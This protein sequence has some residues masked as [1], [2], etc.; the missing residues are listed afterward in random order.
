MH[1]IIVHLPANRDYAGWLEVRGP[2]GRRIAGPF[3]VCGRAD[4]RLAR[5]EGNPE[6]NPLLPGGDTPLGEFSATRI[7]PSGPG[8]PYD[9]EEFG[10]AGVVLLEPRRGDAALADATG[11]F[12]LMIHGGAPSRNGAL[13]PTDGSLRLANRD[14]RTL[15]GV[16]RQAGTVPCHCVPMGA[17]RPKSKVAV[18][19]AAAGS[20]DEESARGT[21]SEPRLPARH[22]AN[23]SRRLWLRNVM[24]A[25]GATVVIPSALIFSMQSAY[26]AAAEGDYSNPNPPPD[27]QPPKPPDPDNTNLI[28]A[29]VTHSGT[30]DVLKGTV[31]DDNNAVKATK[32]ETT[33][34]NGQSNFDKRGSTGVG[35]AETGDNTVT[36][37]TTTTT[38]NGNG[39]GGNGA[40]SNGNGGGTGGNGA[41]NG[42]SAGPAT[43]AGS[44]D[45]Q[46]RA[47]E[48][49]K[50]IQKN[51]PPPKGLK[52]NPVPPPVTPTQ[53]PKKT[54][55]LPDILT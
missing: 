42:G 52:I 41:G 44:D 13:R 23:Q 32:D 16:L 45:Y 15:I 36:V 47:Q 1:K 55:I 48:R 37:T 31:G 40:G 10:A 51:A 33:S 43:G 50:E 26:G 22:L 6:R 8:T 2:G 19:E 24:L 7:V 38:Q 28:A 53:P 9:G 30:L 20:S 27:P 39:A 46:K 5:A 4:D 14:L 54:S 34:D 21:R 17:A 3:P 35:G 49:I 25:T 29:N 18:E 11:R 12:V